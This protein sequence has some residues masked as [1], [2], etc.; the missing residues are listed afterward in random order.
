MNHK[1]SVKIPNNTKLIYCEKKKIIIIIGAL[2]RKSLE[3]KLK[4]KILSLEKR[5]IV[6]S[7]PYT[8]VSNNEKK[9]IKVLQGTTIAHLKQALIETSSLLCQKLK[10]IGVGYRAFS[11]ENYDTQLI[12]FKLGYS[13]S[14]YFCISPELKISCLKLTKLFIFGN[15]YQEITQTAALIRQFRKPEPYKGKGVLYEN[16]KIKLKEGKKV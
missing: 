4:L 9:K 13:H 15:S 11:V 8:N 7:I 6:T 10:F 5:I 2:K 3:L 16:E 14:I 1:Y 12:L